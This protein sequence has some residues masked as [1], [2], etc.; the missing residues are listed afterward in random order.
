MPPLLLWGNLV[1]T[2]SPSLDISPGDPTCVQFGFHGDRG[3]P[4]P[5]MEKSVIYKLHGHLKIPGVAE[6]GLGGFDD[7]AA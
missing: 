1:S 7:V 4:T 6:G 3:T 5:M 2:E